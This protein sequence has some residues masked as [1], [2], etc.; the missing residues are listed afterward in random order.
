M[1]YY[2]Y[3][4]H[5][6]AK[7][8]YTWARLEF[9]SIFCCCICLTLCHIIILQKHKINKI[10]SQD[11][12]IMLDESH[13]FIRF[14]GAVEV[15]QIFMNWIVWPICRPPIPIIMIK[16][17]KVE[18]AKNGKFS[19]WFICL[20]MHFARSRHCDGKMICNSNASN[21]NVFH[22]L[23][24]FF[25]HNCYINIL[26]NVFSMW[27]RLSLCKYILILYT[28]CHA[29]SSLTYKR[30]KKKS[31]FLSIFNSCIDLIC[32]LDYFIYL[33]SSIYF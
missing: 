20:K 29:R 1:I 27:N 17:T 11:V 9:I 23:K 28:H 19:F 12:P 3:I 15:I 13:H 30:T 8:W 24:H 6:H 18:N 22:F 31:M 26:Y 4:V 5:S 33:C 14:Q 21:L 2:A 16:F 7:G 10:I 25:Y 32:C